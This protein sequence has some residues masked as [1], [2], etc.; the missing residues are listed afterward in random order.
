MY[1]IFL[2]LW[3]FSRNRSVVLKIVCLLGPQQPSLAQFC[4]YAVYKT[5]GTQ[6]WSSGLSEGI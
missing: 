6:M 3:T 4:L 2:L 1:D 5:S